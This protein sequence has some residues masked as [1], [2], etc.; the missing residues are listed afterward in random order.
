[1]EVK[2]FLVD[3]EEKSRDTLRNMIKHY[4]AEVLVVGEARTVADAAKKIKELQP[5]LVF[6]DI[7]LP[8]QNGF[9]LFDYF[10][11]PPPFYV[12]FA[13]AYSEYAV[14]AFRMAAVDYLLKPYNIKELKESI[15]RVRERQQ[16][17]QYKERLSSLVQNV[18]TGTKRLALPVQNGYLFIEVE[19]IIRCEADRNYTTFYLQSGEKQV[20]SKPLRLFEEMLDGLHFFRINRS[21]II[22]MNYLKSYGKSKNGYVTLKNGVTLSLSTAKRDEFLELAKEL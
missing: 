14:Q 10:A 21:H 18:E 2:A 16:Q 4:C 5:D 11:S 13:T 17:Q 12:I 1:M 15:R 19:D 8:E 20:V 7:E 6:L 22:N 3:D 9:A